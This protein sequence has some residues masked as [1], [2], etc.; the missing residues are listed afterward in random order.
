MESGQETPESEETMEQ[1]KQVHQ[2]RP[3][4]TGQPASPIGSH[5][6]SGNDSCPKDTCADTTLQRWG[7]YFGVVH[8]DMNSPA[9]ASKMTGIR[10][11][12]AVSVGGRDDENICA[13]YVC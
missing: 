7:P 2:E 9:V 4:P 6:D 8:A 12:T 3:L 13:P 11:V 5:T 10:Q 1:E